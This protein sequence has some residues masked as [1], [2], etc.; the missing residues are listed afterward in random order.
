MRNLARILA[1]IWAG[2]WL[3]FGLASGLNE[4]LG[5]LVIFLRIAIPGL[6]FFI[7]AIIAWHWGKTGGIIL[8]LQGLLILIG[9]PFTSNNISLIGMI[10]VLLFMVLPPLI[11][12]VLFFVEARKSKVLVKAKKD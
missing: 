4:N 7:S 8:V 10:G 5:F 12:G 1:L 9:Y 3:F 2:F 11:A 6:V